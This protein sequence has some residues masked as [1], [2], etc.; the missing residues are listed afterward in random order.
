MQIIK[1][2]LDIGQLGA[3]LIVLDGSLGDYVEVILNDD[4]TTRVSSQVFSVF[5]IQT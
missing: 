5:G 4:F 2:T 3:D 1:G